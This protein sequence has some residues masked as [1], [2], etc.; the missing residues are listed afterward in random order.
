MWGCHGKVIFHAEVRW[1]EE[2]G[3][4]RCKSARVVSG[5]TQARVCS[6]HGWS[7]TAVRGQEI[8]R[9]GRKALGG[10]S[11]KASYH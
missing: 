7:D 10:W 9:G 6:W 1:E 11:G 4:C 2:P 3:N 8:I 5:G